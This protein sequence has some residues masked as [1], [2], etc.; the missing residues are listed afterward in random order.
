MALAVV[1]NLAEA[2]PDLGAARVRKRIDQMNRALPG[3]LVDP[4]P[5][6]VHQM[7]NELDDRHVLAAAV[8]AEVEIIVTFNLRHFPAEACTPAGVE[9]Q[10]PD[11]FADLLV[12]QNPVV[13]WQAIEE[14]AARRRNPP[15][16]PEEIVE[17]LAEE[18]PTAMQR[19]LT[20]RSSGR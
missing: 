14:M 18:I 1:A 16:S 12:T 9:V 11:V 8:A 17:R 4:D 2:R 6:L 5:N 7:T 13:L 15:A 10:H 3:A 20:A 19:L